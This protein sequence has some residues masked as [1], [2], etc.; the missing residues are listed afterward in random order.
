MG[1]TGALSEGRIR[2]AGE[3]HGTRCALIPNREAGEV[4]ADKGARQRD[5]TCCDKWKKKSEHVC[6]GA[7]SEGKIQPS[8]QGA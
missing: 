1:R 3:M 7:L 6:T 5:S 4:R 8:S 2:R